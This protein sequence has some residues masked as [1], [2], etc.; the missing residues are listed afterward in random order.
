MEHLAAGTLNSITS[1]G[2]LSS[3]TV[4]GN[5][6]ASTISGTLTTVAQPNIT[7]QLVS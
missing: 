3:L 1:L 2:N 5:I 7:S 6:T 4:T